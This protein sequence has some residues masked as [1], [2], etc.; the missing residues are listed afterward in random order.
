MYDHLSQLSGAQFDGQFD[1]DMVSDHKQDLGK[2]QKEAKSKG[3]LG[4][5]VQQT[6]PTLQKHLQTAESLTSQNSRR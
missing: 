1:Q 4:D 3:P 2:F 6:I 5:F